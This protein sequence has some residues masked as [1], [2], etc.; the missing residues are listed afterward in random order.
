MLSNSLGIDPDSPR[1]DLAKAIERD[2]KTDHDIDRATGKHELREDASG[3]F[4]VSTDRERGLI[5]AEHRFGGVLVKRYEADRAVT[6]RARG[7]CRYGG[8]PAFARDVAR[9]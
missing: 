3:Y 4:V 1:F 6:N 7:G 5:V 9:S 2:W 8:Q